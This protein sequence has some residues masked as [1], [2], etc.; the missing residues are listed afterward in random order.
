ML[1][2]RINKPNLGIWPKL[3]NSAVRAVRLPPRLWFLPVL[4]RGGSCQP[5]PCTFTPPLAQIS[6]V[7]VNYTQDIFFPEDEGVKPCLTTPL[8]Q[9]KQNSNFT[10]M[11]EAFL[12]LIFG[13]REM[14]QHINCRHTMVLRF[15]WESLIIYCRT[16]GDKLDNNKK[17]SPN[18]AV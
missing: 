17:C 16:S 1:N 9:W 18:A 8:H 12:K 2:P 10:V 11:F 14:S 4:N 7:L 6:G 5:A 13:F 15:C 3:R